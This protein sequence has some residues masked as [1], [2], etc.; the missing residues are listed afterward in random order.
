MLCTAG[1]ENSPRDTSKHR[2]D[3][4]PRGQ[5]P[6][7]TISCQSHKRPH[8]QENRDYELS[9]LAACSGETQPETDVISSA[10]YGK[11]RPA[12]LT[13]HTDTEAPAAESCTAVGS[14]SR[15]SSCSPPGAGW[16]F[17]APYLPNDHTTHRG[18][19]AA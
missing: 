16:L 3:Q 2:A 12:S 19:T 10:E 8:S 15:T 18:R 6:L 11:W 4:P 9:A 17:G 5:A 14:C 1:R 13:S 7:D